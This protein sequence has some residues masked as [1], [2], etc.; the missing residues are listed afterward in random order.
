M[1]WLEY[2]RRSRGWTQGDLAGAL[3]PGFTGGT[4]S[5]LESGRLKPS[6]RQAARLAEV[7]ATSAEELLATVTEPDL[8]GPISG[9]A[10]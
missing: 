1:T 3:G 2:R 6:A 4:I 8:R 10:T 9:A 7:F 5:L